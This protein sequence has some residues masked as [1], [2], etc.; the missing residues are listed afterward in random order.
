MNHMEK[1]WSE[2]TFSSSNNLPWRTPF[3]SRKGRKLQNK[4]QTNLNRF[5][6]NVNLKYKQI[7]F[8]CLWLFHCFFLHIFRNCHGG[9]RDDFI[10][11]LAYLNLRYGINSTWKLTSAQCHDSENHQHL[12]YF[13]NVHCVINNPIRDQT[14]EQTTTP[15]TYTV[16]AYTL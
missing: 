4:D 14:C 3:I 7:S 12:K 10:T 2:Q 6:L 13:C 1:A 15:L 5:A 8:C 11:E 9:G 16:T